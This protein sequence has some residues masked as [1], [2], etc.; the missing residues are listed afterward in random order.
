MWRGTDRALPE[1]LPGDAGERLDADAREQSGTRRFL[2]GRGGE[3]DGD[4]S[5]RA[6]LA[7]AITHWRG[8]RHA[9]GGGAFGGNAVEALAAYAAA[10]GMRHIFLCPAR[11]VSANQV[12]AVAYRRPR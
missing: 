7:L 6:G 9:E 8:T 5:R 2:K 12:E 11:A 1:V 3:S 10:A 4:I